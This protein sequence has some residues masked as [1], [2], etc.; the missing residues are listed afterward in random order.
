MTHP[1]RT[2][3]AQITIVTISELSLP[4]KYHCPVPPVHIEEGRVDHAA[5][6]CQ[7]GPELT[8]TGK[9]LGCHHELFN[10]MLVWSEIV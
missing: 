2:I 4:I 5:S 7:T 9:Y 6:Q 3:S 8:N 1:H 10:A